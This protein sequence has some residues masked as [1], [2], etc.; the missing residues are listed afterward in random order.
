MSLINRLRSQDPDFSKSLRAL[1]AFDAEQD[2]SIEHVVS[3]VLK[4]L[5]HRG[6]EALL[7]Y[8]RR[9]DRVEAQSVQ[10]L[11]I[12]REEWLAALEALPKD[13]R[14][15]LEEAARRVRVYHERQKAESWSYTEP[16]GTI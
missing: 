12:P 9:F 6:D 3:D 5:R 2:D 4:D 1:L 16:D 13:Q 11:E 10:A 7:E 14:A 8:T 15:A